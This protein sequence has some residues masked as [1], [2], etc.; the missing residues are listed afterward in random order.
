MSMPALRF[1]DELPVVD[2]DHIRDQLKMPETST[3]RRLCD[4]VGLAVTTLVEPEF[5]VFRDLNWYPGRG[6]PIAPDVMVLPADA[7]GDEPTSYRQDRTDGP[8]PVAVVE[9]PSDSDTFVSL[10]A[11]AHRYQSLET[12]AYLIVP[13]PTQPRVLRLAP[14]DAEPRAWT[15]T[16][17]DELGGIRLEIDD[18]RIVLV[19]PSGVRASSDAEFLAAEA[20]RRAAEHATAAEERIAELERRLTERSPSDPPPPAG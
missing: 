7:V 3:H 10:L 4:L 18:E 11:K 6:G 16:P 17:I 15:G 9:V 8:P 14:D 2:V 20:D 1:G 13:G 5:R 12:V 19:T